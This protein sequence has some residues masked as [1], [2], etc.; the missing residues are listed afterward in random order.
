MTPELTCLA[1]TALFTALMFV[2]YVL[3]R[4][5]VRGIGDTMGY[6]DQPK[7][8]SAW[9]LRM[10]AAHANAVENLAVFATLVLIA[11]AADIHGQ[12]TVTASALYLGS[13][14][15]HFLAYT[16]A[17]PWLRTLAFTGGLFAQLVFAWLILA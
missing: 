8:Q 2:P 3:D 6:P 11:H 5:A 4:L 1:W 10:K 14:V 16:F 13:R 9:A 12:L 15:V 17:V 7:P